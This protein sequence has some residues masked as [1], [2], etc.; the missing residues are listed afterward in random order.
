[1]NS[2]IRKIIKNVAILALSILLIC[3]GFKLAIFY[4]PFIIAFALYL[5]IEPIIKFCMKK[6]KFKRKHSALHILIIFISIIVGLLGW[7]IAT[8]IS[9]TSNL[10]KNLN[11]YVNII[12]SFIQSKT[13]SNYD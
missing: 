2:N 11:D 9:E 7:G 10:L 3:L 6:L 13:S 1:M 5:L 8:I 12:Y 4:M